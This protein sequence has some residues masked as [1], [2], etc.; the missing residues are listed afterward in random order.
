MSQHQELNIMLRAQN[1]NAHISPTFTLYS[2]LFPH[3]FDGM[4]ARGK[5]GISTV[6]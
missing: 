4:V 1:V 5:R 2:A 3:A 6:V